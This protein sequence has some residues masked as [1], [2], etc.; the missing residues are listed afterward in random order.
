MNDGQIAI[1][2]SSHKSFT[3]RAF[4]MLFL[5]LAAQ[6]MTETARDALFLS[7]LPATQLPWMYVLV[8][9]ACF[10]GVARSVGSPRLQPLLSSRGSS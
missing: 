1:D 7:R 3:R 8:A 10:V 2:G 9:F 4:G 6:S 5:I